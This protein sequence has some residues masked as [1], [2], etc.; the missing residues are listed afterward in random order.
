VGVER[1]TDHD[2]AAD[3]IR[4]LDSKF[5]PSFDAV[6]AGTDIRIICT[7]TRAPRANAIAERFIGSP[8][9]EPR[10]HPDHRAPHLAAVLRDYV[11]HVN[12][13]R[14]HRSLHQRPMAL[15]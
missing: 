11:Q 12:K 1:G 9:R 3:L 8:R 10:P 15:L 7:P 6:F 4:D 14:P 5:A 2:L 13:H